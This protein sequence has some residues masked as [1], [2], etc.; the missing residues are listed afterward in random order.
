MKSVIRYTFYELRIFFST[1]LVVHLCILH[2]AIKLVKNSFKE[3][4]YFKS[5]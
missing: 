4:K 2:L 5:R 3:S 1:P